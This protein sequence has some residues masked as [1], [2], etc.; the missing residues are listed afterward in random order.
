MHR[1]HPPSPASPDPTGSDQETPPSMLP[2][3][4]PPPPPPRSS[5]TSLTSQTPP[6]KINV[7]LGTPLPPT[8]PM[9]PLSPPRLGS[10]SRSSP[11]PMDPLL[12][13]RQESPQTGQ[14][15]VPEQMA[16]V[17]TTGARPISSAPPLIASASA[18]APASVTP[19]AGARSSFGSGDPLHH[20]MFLTPP[21]SITPSLM[22]TPNPTEMFIP[23]KK[24]HTKTLCSFMLFRSC[25]FATFGCTP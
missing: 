6:Q 15:M 10:P 14:P 16:V 17:M 4:W 18:A 23:V 22:I 21:P 19:T 7:G 9:V 24:S 2:H 1:P 8:K 13:P 5:S 11:K 25:L 3:L 12:L 20:A